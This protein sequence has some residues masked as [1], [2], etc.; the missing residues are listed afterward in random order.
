MARE[1]AN[2]GVMLILEN[3]QPRIAVPIGEAGREAACYFA[4]NDSAESATANRITREA[5]GV[6]GAWADLDWD[7]MK[8]ALDRIRRES[9]PTPPI[10]L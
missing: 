1:S 5:I 4:E 7:E 10:E 9:V 6:L 2:H 8:H 3:D